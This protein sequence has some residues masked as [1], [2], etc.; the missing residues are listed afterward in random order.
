MVF[1]FFCTIIQLHLTKAIFFLFAHRNQCPS[2][3]PRLSGDLRAAGLWGGI[4]WPLTPPPP[5]E[6]PPLEISPR[7]HSTPRPLK[8]FS[9]VNSFE[10]CDS[11]RWQS[12]P[13]PWF[14]G[15]PCD[16]RLRGRIGKG[17]DSCEKMTRVE[18]CDT[19]HVAWTETDTGLTVQ[20]RL[21][22]TGRFGHFETGP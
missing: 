17:R 1:R 9:F 13:P 7:G 18:E 3:I 10:P 20:G 11:C 14:L 16:R 19:R 6:P 5:P 15:A 4:K 22:L 21:V 8:K 12:P 2:P